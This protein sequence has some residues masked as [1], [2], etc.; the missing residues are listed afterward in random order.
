MKKILLLFDRASVVEKQADPAHLKGLLSKSFD[1]IAYEYATYDDLIFAI[2]NQ[3][4]SVKISS[5]DTDLSDF[6]VIYFRRFSKDQARGM[7][8]AMY[9]QNSG[10]TI[11]DSEI[12]TRKGSITKLTQYMKLAMRGIPIPDT[13]CV[14][15]SLLK[16]LLNSGKITL[17]YPCIMKIADATRGDAN[18]LVQSQADAIKF[19]VG[20]PKG[21]VLIQEYI[22]NDGDYRVWVLGDKIGPVFYRQRNSSDTHKNNTSQGAA[23]K[24][25]ENEAEILPLQHIALQSAK[26][27]NREIAGVDVVQSSLDPSD[28]RIFEVNRAPQ[29]EHTPLEQLKA[30]ELSAYLRNIAYGKGGIY[31]KNEK[32]IGVSSFIDFIE[33]RN[34]KKIPARID[35][36]ARTS[37]LWVSDVRIVEGE[38][39]FKLFGPSSSFYTGKVVKKKVVGTRQVTSSTGHVQNRPV[40]VM[41]IIINNKRLNAKFTLSDR[42]T[43][44]YPVLI[45]RNTLRGN[46]L[47]DSKDT[48][49]AMLYKDPIEVNEFNECEEI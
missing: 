15:Q 6:S 14:E 3:E 40:V 23:L 48:G 36:G 49:E 30:N 12:I 37:S 46:F 35:S 10:V 8:A 25:I 24:L 28:Y 26:V 20:H 38:A 5:T 17:N 7:A 42:T 19:I 45:G 13:L 27:L 11:L 18:E 4:C 22:Q 39:K 34:I 21:E 47:V 43:Q 44:V 41:P 16:K 9:A 1:D 2:N 29:V 31:E 33:Y 32:V